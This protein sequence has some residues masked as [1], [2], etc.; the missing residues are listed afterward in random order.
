MVVQYFEAD[1]NGDLYHVLNEEEATH[2][3]LD[4]EDYERLK[5]VYESGD[6]DYL[7]ARAKNTSDRNFQQAVP[8]D[9][10]KKR[11][12]ELELALRSAR[13][14][15]T[16]EHSM[17]EG[18]RRIFKERANADR[19]LRPKKEH[20]GYVIQ[21]ST[22]KEKFGFVNKWRQTFGVMETVLETPYDAQFN[23]GQVK[24]ESLELTQKRPDGS[25]LVDVVG[26]GP[27]YRPQSANAS[28]STIC[29]EVASF[30]KEK[31]EQARRENLILFRQFKFNA[32][33]GYWE[34][35]LTHMA[36]LRCYHA[37]MMPSKKKAQTD[38]QENKEQT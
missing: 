37:T 8:Y 14:H 15:A 18:F 26:L 3:L 17:N 6:V 13:N 28:L 35:T 34:V 10:D 36:P 19:K 9:T 32:K 21:V 23:M 24:I 22:E 11:I 33:S 27:L 20:T 2:I 1:E 29:N 38:K 12:Q 7:I 16:Y 25:R 5:R 30:S 31:F 4:I